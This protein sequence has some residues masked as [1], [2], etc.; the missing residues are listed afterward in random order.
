MLLPAEFEH[1]GCQAIVGSRSWPSG[2]LDYARRCTC[3]D[4]EVSTLLG[5]VC[6]AL[7]G[8]R[9]FAGSGQIRV[10]VCSNLL[11]RGFSLFGDNNDASYL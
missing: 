7:Y 5:S 8:I 2:E 3:S 11:C 4:A 6:R 10:V 9:D 1:R